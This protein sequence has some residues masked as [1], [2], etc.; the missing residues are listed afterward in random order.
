MKL[1]KVFDCADMPSEV[2][3]AFFYFTEGICN[4]VYVSWDIGEDG[5]TDDESIKKYKMVDKW[6]FE[7]GATEEFEE[8]L[9]H[10]WW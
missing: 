8:V 4:S 2:E 5:L 9:I 10:H 1:M 7:N 6:L 3:Q